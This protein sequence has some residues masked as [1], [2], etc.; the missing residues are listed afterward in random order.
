M[1]GGAKSAVNFLL[2]S[3]LSLPLN[4]ASSTRASQKFYHQ[5]PDPIAPDAFEWHELTHR[6]YVDHT[7][8]VT[9][10]VVRLYRAI[11]GRSALLCKGHLWLADPYER[12]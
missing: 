7:P 8:A 3:P 5:Q 12:G 2:F 1:R 10:T 11:F 9:F 6:G 4:D